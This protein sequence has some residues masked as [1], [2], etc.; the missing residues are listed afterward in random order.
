M[1]DHFEGR[2]HEPEGRRPRL[3]ESVRRHGV[4]ASSALSVI[5]QELVKFS[6]SYILDQMFLICYH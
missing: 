4:V 6:P 1:E 3:L 2:N 5:I